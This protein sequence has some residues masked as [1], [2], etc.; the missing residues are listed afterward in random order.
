MADL[1]EFELLSLD[2]EEHSFVSHEVQTCPLVTRDVLDMG[3][4][5]AQRGLLG[6]VISIHGKNLRDKPQDRRIYMN[7]DAPS[8]GLVCGVQVSIS[9]RF[10]WDID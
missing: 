5:F 3:E 7:L 10:I 2:N 9:L 1:R 4:K 6:G 8:S